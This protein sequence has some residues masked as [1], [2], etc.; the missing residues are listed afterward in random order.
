MQFSDKPLI[1]TANIDEA[2]DI[3]AY[4]GLGFTP[5]S[6]FDWQDFQIKLYCAQY[7]ELH[8]ASTAFQTTTKLEMY[9]GREHYAVMVPISGAFQVEYGHFHQATSTGEMV[10]FSPER[11]LT[12]TQGPGCQR[13]TVYVPSD[14]VHSRLEQLLGRPVGQRL[15]FDHAPNAF[16]N[17][18]RYLLHSL[19][20][21]FQAFSNAAA[22]NS[23]TREGYEQ[24]MEEL[25]DHML[26]SL[27]H[28]YT[29]ALTKRVPVHNLPGDVI[30]ALEYIHTH[31]DGDVTLGSLI[32]ISG[33][34]GR[35]LIHHFNRFLGTSPVR[36]ARFNRFEMVNT[37]LRNSHDPDATVSSVANK[38]G[39]RHMGRFAVEYRRLFGELPSQTLRS[40]RFD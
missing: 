26:L 15:E 38:Y 13:I 2:A 35:T 8:F 24:F 34:P 31:T 6:R 14:M 28:N 4:K 37:E 10:V 30:R 3:L 9:E 33:V 5:A 11:H 16:R 39:F 1:D 7:P 12:L 40:A 36:Y 18:G 23:P 17:G 21:V 27:R 19:D 32:N 25:L 22:L 29:S 20:H